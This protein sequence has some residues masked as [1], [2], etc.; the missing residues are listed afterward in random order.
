MA[1]RRIWLNSWEWACCG[2]PFVTGDTVEFAVTSPPPA[3]LAEYLVDD[4]AAAIDAVESHHEDGGDQRW[5]GIVH[6]VSAVATPHL[7][8]RIR[9]PPLPAGA[10]RRPTFQLGD[11]VSAG[12]IAMG[13][14]PSE[15]MT[16]V[17]PV[18]GAPEF[19][20]IMGVRQPSTR[21]KE[22]PRTELPEP[23]VH[24]R[25]VAYLVELDVTD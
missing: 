16:S 5:S 13:G 19:T 14:S 11:G 20:T 21:K 17:E 4:A 24:H 6:S 7:V 8:T 23:G 1:I 3:W 18:A 12:A 10:V 22:D 2:E 9:R 15:W 25:L